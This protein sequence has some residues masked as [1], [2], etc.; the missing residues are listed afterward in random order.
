MASTCPQPLHVTAA[1]AASLTLIQDCGV[2]ALVLAGAYSLVL[3]F[4]SLSKQNLIQQVFFLPFSNI[5]LEER[6]YR[7]F[8]IRCS[9]DE[10][11]NIKCGKKR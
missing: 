6:R 7:I 8:Q 3:A 4:E 5:I 2:T 1:R 11:E 9:A 10:D